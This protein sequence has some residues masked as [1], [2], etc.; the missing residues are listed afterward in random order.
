M[1]KTKDIIITSLIVGTLTPG[2]TN[3]Y[4]ENSVMIRILRDSKVM[5]VVS[6]NQV[7]KSYPIAVGK[8]EKPTPIGDFTVINKLE[9]PVW[10]P[11]G[12]EPVPS[13]KNNPLGSRW[14]GLSIKGYGIHGTNQPASIGK[15]ASGGC[16]RMKDKDLKELF[17]IISI[18]TSVS[19]THS[20]VTPDLTVSLSTTCPKTSSLAAISK[21]STSR[22]FN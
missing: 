13:G 20:E 2:W 8:K 12:K 16:I 5:Q 3:T 6:G 9:N 4:S 17:G 11:T 18:G 22:P 1:H 19:I 15:A 21:D 10:Y 7:I 14:L